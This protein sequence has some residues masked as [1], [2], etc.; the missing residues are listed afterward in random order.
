MNNKFTEEDKEK[1]IH[2][3]NF[4]AKNAEFKV[5][6]QEIIDYF[7]LLNHMQTSILP[8]VEEHILEVKRVIEKENK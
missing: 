2:F 5:N 4:V 7:K 8:K 3:L 6:T 1:L